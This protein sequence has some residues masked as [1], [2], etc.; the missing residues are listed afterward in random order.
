MK[1]IYIAVD[2]MPKTCSECIYWHEIP[3]N[4][5]KGYCDAIPGNPQASWTQIAEKQ[6]MAW[7][8]PL[9]KM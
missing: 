4:P 2:N 5:E 1:M 3:Q 8:C 6:I 7:T 9:Q